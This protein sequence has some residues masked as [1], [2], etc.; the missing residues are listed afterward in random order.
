MLSYL[1]LL[2]CL[3][4][5]HMATAAMCPDNFVCSHP[6]VNDIEACGN[7]CTPHGGVL[8]A[9]LDKTCLSPYHGVL[10]RCICVS[11]SCETVA[12][13]HSLRAPDCN[14]GPTTQ[15]EC[16]AR[17]G[18]SH[19]NGATLSS[20]ESTSGTIFTCSCPGCYALRTT[21]LVPYPPITLSPT[22]KPTTL[23][24]TTHMPT[25]RPSPAPTTQWNTWGSNIRFFVIAGSMLA[26]GILI[27][28][29]CCIYHFRCHC[30]VNVSE[31]RRL[32]P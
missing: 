11:Y 12:F 10:I 14:D 18:L 15:A 5:T 25:M 26:V 22:E 23:M 7:F 13:F 4:C 16:N 19:F 17:C 24:P 20:Q 3:W 6:F 27:S 21:A 2:V 9:M 28:I 32:L 8:N 29:G 1:F 30:I 31:R